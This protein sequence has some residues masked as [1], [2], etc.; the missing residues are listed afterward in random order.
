MNGKLNNICFKFIGPLG[1]CHF[2]GNE[3]PAWQVWRARK[4]ECRRLVVSRPF[5]TEVVLF[6]LLLFPPPLISSFP[7]FSLLLFPL[8]LPSSISSFSSSTPPPPPPF[9]VP[10]IATKSACPAN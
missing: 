4:V 10:E 9:T 3:I 2:N 6:L 7:F 8:L 1:R 5:K